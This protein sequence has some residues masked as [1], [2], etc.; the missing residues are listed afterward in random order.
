MH[1]DRA[2]HS[3][4]PI[5]RTRRMRRRSAHGNKDVDAAPVAETDAVAVATQQAHIRPYALDF[6]HITDGVVPTGLPRYAA[7]E[8]QPP[9]E[10]RAAADHRAHRV[11]HGGH[12]GLL[13]T[14]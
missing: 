1:F 5:M 12:G 7:Q 9:F 11:Q 3:I 10:R 8:D 14:Q 13:L 6:N 4:A 2:S